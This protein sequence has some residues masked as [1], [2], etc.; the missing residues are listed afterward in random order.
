MAMTKYT[1]T[2]ANV[3]DVLPITDGFLVSLSMT[4]RGFRWLAAF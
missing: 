1:L 4:Q 3:G 2:D